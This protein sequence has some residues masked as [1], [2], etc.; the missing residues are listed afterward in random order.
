MLKYGFIILML[1]TSCMPATQSHYKAK[2]PTM[3]GEVVEL[4]IQQEFA[5]TKCNI[6]TS[7][8]IIVRK[9]RDLK[10]LFVKMGELPTLGTEPI[11]WDRQMI[12]AV[13]MG[14]RE[15]GSEIYIDSVFLKDG[16]LIILVQRVGGPPTAAKVQPYHMVVV[17]RY[18][19]LPVEFRNL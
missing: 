11:Q 18:D 14:E 3:P 5:G 4:E 10:D 6:T 12:I 19:N 2:M 16:K 7:M 8:E 1:I 17:P 13:F 15:E 9:D